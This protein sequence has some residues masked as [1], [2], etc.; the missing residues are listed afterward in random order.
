MIERGLDRARVRTVG[1]KRDLL[2]DIQKADCRDDCA[3]GVIADPLQHQLVGQHG[4]TG[5]QQRCQHQR[6]QE[7]KR[8]MTAH[9]IGD[10]PG[11]YR[12]DHEEFAVRDIDHPH[13]PEDKR[14]AE[15]HQRQHG[16]GDQS[17]KETKNQ[18]GPEFHAMRLTPSPQSVEKDIR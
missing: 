2:D 18:I 17:L 8:R 12:A 5:R 15:C 10:P 6:G 1:H 13:H 14:Q 7:A 4:E 16:G 9:Q 11:Q 3:F